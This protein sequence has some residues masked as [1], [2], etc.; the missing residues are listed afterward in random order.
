MDQALDVDAGLVGQPGLAHVVGLVGMV[1]VLPVVGRVDEAQAV[2]EEAVTAARAHGNPFWI[3]GSL[4]AFGRAFADADP[5]RALDAMRQALVVTRDHRLVGSRRSCPEK[6][7][8]SKPSTATLAR[9]S[10]LFETAIDSLHRAGDVGNTAVALADLAVLFDRLERPEIAATLYGASRLHG[11]FGWVTHLPDVV[12]HL[13]TILGHAVFDDYVGAGAAMEL[14]RRRRLR[15]R[16]D[17]SRSPPTRG[18]HLTAPR[19]LPRIAPL[20]RHH[21]YR[22]GRS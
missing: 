16:P 7:P 14:S 10:S 1:L 12:N 5:T 4:D 11:D 20:T 17:P 8:V 13:R 15:P 3:A 2:A 6:P 22:S 18:R 21:R 9:P 19:S